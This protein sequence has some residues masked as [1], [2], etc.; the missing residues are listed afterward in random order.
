[1]L[2]SLQNEFF[3][4]GD[5][6]PFSLHN[7]TVRAADGIEYNMAEPAQRQQAADANTNLWASKTRAAI[8]AH[9]PKTMVT[10][11]VFTFNAVQ[12]SGP[13]G[14]MLDGCNPAIPPADPEKHVDCRFP[15][16]PLKLAHA[17]LDYLDV[18]IYQADGSYVYRTRSPLLDLVSSCLTRG[19][20]I[21]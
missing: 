1:M 6:F 4:Q 19:W 10:V 15:A 3:L 20:H 14:L 2:V 11:G 16:R 18:H 13:N 9:L 21:S 5:S 8:R 17:G 12:K 7:I